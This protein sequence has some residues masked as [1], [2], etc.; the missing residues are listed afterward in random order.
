M[1]DIKSISPEE[2]AKLLEE[3]WVYVDVRSEP[4]YEAGH[5]PGSLNVPLLHAGPGGMVPNPE[6]MDV[7]KSAF[8]KD[9]KLVMGCRSGQRSLRAA[10]MLA[11]DGFG[12]LANLSTGFEGTRDSFGRVV[13]G[14]G[15]VG[16][17]V[18]SG[19]P[20]GQRYADAKTR[21]PGG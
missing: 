12:T 10:Q 14:W 2:A 15:K 19:A 21:K 4:E 3:G 20:E 5:V 1:S 8:S 17:P 7:M 16:L 6:F 18:E 11:A 9:E 13:P